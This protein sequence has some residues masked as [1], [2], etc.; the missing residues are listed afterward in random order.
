[1]KNQ[2]NEITSRLNIE[3]RIFED[4]IVTD[5]YQT[6]I[7]RQLDNRG[8]TEKDIEIASFEFILGEELSI[9][10]ILRS[11]SFDLPKAKEMP[12]FSISFLASLMP[13]VS[14]KITGY[15]SMLR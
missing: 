6:E 9:I 12:F 2:V 3:N 4:M 5:N 1:M 8:I 13:A 10:T 7:F 15:P 14:A 11:A